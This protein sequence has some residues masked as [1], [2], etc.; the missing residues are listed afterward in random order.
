[1]LR[2][3]VFLL[4]AA[5][6]AAAQAKW[7]VTLFAVETP[8]DLAPPTFRMLEHRVIGLDDAPIS[9]RVGD[10]DVTVDIR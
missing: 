5:W 6:S 8:T 2:A 3:V 1:M 9:V 4:L 7:S 10:T